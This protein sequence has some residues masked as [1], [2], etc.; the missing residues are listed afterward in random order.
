MGA[1]GE[2]V[3]GERAAGGRPGQGLPAGGCGVE[4]WAGAS[5]VRGV[6]LSWPLQLQGHC[7]EAA[8]ML[9]AAAIDPDK[10]GGRRPRPSAAGPTNKNNPPC[11][12]ECH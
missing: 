5:C 6:W 7:L 3:G 11:R 8:S 9:V 4:W 12:Q 2:G 1:A 10:N